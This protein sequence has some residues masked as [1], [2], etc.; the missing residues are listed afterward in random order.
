MGVYIVDMLYTNMKKADLRYEK[1]LDY[2]IEVGVAEKTSGIDYIADILYLLFN[3]D[4]RQ[5]TVDKDT[6]M[7][8]NMR[9]AGSTLEEI[10]N[11]FNTST[12]NVQQKLKLNGQVVK[13]NL[14]GRL[15]ENFAETYGQSARNIKRAVNYAITKLYD[16][17]K[18]TELYNKMFGEDNLTDK[19]FIKRSYLYLKE[20]GV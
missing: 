4:E 3:E 8:V 16:S 17:P 2:L 10:A 9:L 19:V 5:T 13:F 20:Q 14:N 18:H 7:M 15:Y 6:R 1:I 12:W 11:T